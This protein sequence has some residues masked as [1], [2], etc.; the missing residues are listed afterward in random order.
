MTTL[1]SLYQELTEL[2]R[3][4]IENFSICGMMSSPIFWLHTA[5]VYDTPVNLRLVPTLREYLAEIELEFKE[6]LVAIINQAE[7]LLN[8]D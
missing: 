8:E 6:R 2:N 3:E 5:I 7:R 1:Q 4:L